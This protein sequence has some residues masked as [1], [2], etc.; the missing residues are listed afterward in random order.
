MKKYFNTIDNFF[1]DVDNKSDNIL[2]FIVFFS[3][4]ILMEFLNQPTLYDFII[5]VSI[6]AIRLVWDFTN[7]KSRRRK[8][9]RQTLSI[10]LALT[11]LFVIIWFVIRI[12]LPYPYGILY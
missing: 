2:T 1:E 11:T 10:V 9:Y 7:T 3:V 12:L 4:M 5:I 8:R 6:F